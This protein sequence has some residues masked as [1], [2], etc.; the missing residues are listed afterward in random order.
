MKST[1]IVSM[2]VCIFLAGCPLG[3]QG[4]FYQVNGSVFKAQDVAVYRINV[5][6]IVLSWHPESAP[7]AVAHHSAYKSEVLWKVT[8]LRPIQLAGLNFELFETPPGFRLDIDRTRN[9]PRFGSFSLEI[10]TV[11]GG[12]RKMFVFHEMSPETIARIKSD[13]PASH[14][15]PS[16]G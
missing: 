14:Q 8:A 7:D 3:D 11:A 5:S 4:I 1:A 9:L 13:Y 12:K 10:Y 6:D 2:C 15:N 16:S